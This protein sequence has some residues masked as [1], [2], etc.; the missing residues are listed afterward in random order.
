MPDLV[1]PQEILSIEEYNQKR[2][3]IKKKIF[4]IKSTNRFHVGNLFTFL[5]EN[6]DTVWYQIQEMIRAEGI[7]SNEGILHEVQTYNELIP[8]EGQIKCTLLIEIDDIEMRKFK[9]RELKGLHEHV[10]LFFKN[11]ASEKKIVGVFDDRQFDRERISSVQYITFQ[12]E[13][14]DYESL[15]NAEEIGIQVTHP[16]YYYKTALNS[17]QRKSV[18]EDFKKTLS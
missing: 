6:K 11:G 1:T 12:I 4:E 17:E 10:F 3:E 7:R 9:L 13:K 18:L 15:L 8:L 14:E 2:E 5:F 16:S